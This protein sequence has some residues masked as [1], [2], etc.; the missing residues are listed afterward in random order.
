M[1]MKLAN[2]QSC[3]AFCA[4][5]LQA[6]REALDIVQETCF[7]APPSANWTVEYHAFHTET[8]AAYQTSMDQCVCHALLTAMRQVIDDSMGQNVYREPICGL[9]DVSKRLSSGSWMVRPTHDL[10][11]LEE[12]PCETSD[13]KEE[14]GRFDI[15]PAEDYTT[16]RDHSNPWLFATSLAV[17]L[18]NWRMKAV[19]SRRKATSTLW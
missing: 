8:F 18:L 14:P 6:H 5:E 11:E 3:Q 9:L 12:V 19:S 15:V 4:T 7:L 17:Y 16:I 13:I 10:W 1:K 2:Q